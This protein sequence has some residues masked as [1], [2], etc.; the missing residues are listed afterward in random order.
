[1]GFT[2]GRVLKGFGRP[3]PTPF[4]A[5]LYFFVVFAKMKD[6]GYDG[7][8]RPLLFFLYRRGLLPWVMLRGDGLFNKWRS[9]NRV[10]L[11]TLKDANPLKG[12]AERATSYLMSG[13]ADRYRSPEIRV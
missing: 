2:A 10:C 1:M 7:F 8:L 12:G 11:K 4:G 9:S 13:W 6:E 5:P 3:L